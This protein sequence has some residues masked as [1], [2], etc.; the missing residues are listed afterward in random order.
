MVREFGACGFENA[1]GFLAGLGF[2]F[3]LLS[4]HGTR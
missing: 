2:T 3:L 1:I 4:L